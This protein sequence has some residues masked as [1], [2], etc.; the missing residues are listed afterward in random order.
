MMKRA[1]LLA[2]FL[3]S[4]ALGGCAPSYSHTDISQVSTNE[5]PGTVTV[6][7]IQV[8]QGGIVTAHIAPFNSDEKPMVGDVVS[9]D[10]SILEVQRAYGDK[11]YAF[12]GIKP[13]TTH[14]EFRAD[15]VTVAIIQAEVTAQTTR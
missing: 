15:G 12:L 3:S 8:T 14:V 1:L 9:Q 6:P 2:S 13:G 4:V 7:R 5:L 11:N 10:R